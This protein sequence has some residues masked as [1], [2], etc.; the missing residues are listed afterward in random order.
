MRHKEQLRV[1]KAEVI[2]DLQSALHPIKRAIHV[3]ERHT[4][5]EQRQNGLGCSD[6][7]TSIMMGQTANFSPRGLVTDFFGEA[8]MQTVGQQ[9][10]F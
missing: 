10:G 6:C 9:H 2:T 8:H 3:S 4:G 5:T 7:I 1:L